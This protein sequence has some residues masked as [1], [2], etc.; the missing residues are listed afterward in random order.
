MA[1]HIYLT[2]TVFRRTCFY[3]IHVHVHKRYIIIS[4]ICI[5]HDNYKACIKAMVLC[6]TPIMAMV[7]CMTPIMAMVLCMT[8]IMAMVLCMTP[9][10][11]MVLCMTPIMAMVLCMTPINRLGTSNRFLSLRNTLTAVN[12]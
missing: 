2:Y 7:L 3:G 4:H 8:P 10:M 5:G 1:S 6:M 12:L 11:A 9:I